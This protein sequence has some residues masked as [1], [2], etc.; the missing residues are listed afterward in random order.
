[1][2]LQRNERLQ[3]FLLELQ[4]PIGVGLFHHRRG[5]GMTTVLSRRRWRRIDGHMR[6]R[7]QEKMT[8]VAEDSR[9]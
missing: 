9:R 3:L 6:K 1:V 5:W 2:S 7:E 4:A 8:R